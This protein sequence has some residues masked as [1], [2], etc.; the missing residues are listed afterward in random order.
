MI[1][2]IA[3]AVGVV[4]VGLV[5]LLALGPGGGD[6]PSNRWV[7]LRAPEIA[8]ATYDGGTYDLDDARGRWV[9]VNVF[10]SWCP[11]CVREHPE[12]TELDAWGRETG[13]AEVV[14]IAFQDTPE[15]I[16]DFFARYGGDWPV[17]DDSQL[18]LQLG[19]SQVPET[20]LVSPSGLVAAHV[21]GE[22]TAEGI[23]GLIDDL[24]AS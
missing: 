14:S 17:L 23:I 5:A 7:G 13:R 8:G 4:V 1:R 19:V 11:P 2:W 9:V 22:V 6:E 10:G 16:A 21:P 24:E 20:F 12:L 18:V 15:G 3:G